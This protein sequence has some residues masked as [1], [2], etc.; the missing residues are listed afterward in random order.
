M[1]RWP[2]LHVQL[3]FR[4]IVHSEE[5]SPWADDL[6]GGI[7]LDPFAD[8]PTPEDIVHGHFL[9]AKEIWGRYGIHLHIHRDGVSPLYHD[10]YFEISPLYD[11]GYEL[12]DLEWSKGQNFLNVYYTKSIGMGSGGGWRLGYTYT[13]HVVERSQRATTVLIAG[14]PGL[15]C[16]WNRPLGWVLAHELGHAFGLPHTFEVVEPPME[17]ACLWPFDDDTP[18]EGVD[19]TF[20]LMSYPHNRDDHP[21]EEEMVE[22]AFLTDSQIRRARLT[23]LSRRS[24][25]AWLVD[26]ANLSTDELKN[27]FLERL[28]SSYPTDYPELRQLF[29]LDRDFPDLVGEFHASW[30]G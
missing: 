20:N 4:Y 14:D 28:G 8:L 23:L 19:Q 2:E 30:L 6:L 26:M 27:D 21:S 5:G 13:T 22:H 15:Q 12:A 16:F 18:Y 11:V 24:N 7:G 3:R 9:T 17:A 10:E 25:L 1:S 29:V